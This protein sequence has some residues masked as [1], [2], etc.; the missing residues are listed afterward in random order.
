MKQYAKRMPHLPNPLGTE[1]E[2][3]K[4]SELDMLQRLDLLF[5]LCEWQ[6]TG[7][8]RLRSMMNEEDEL[9]W[10]S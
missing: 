3:I 5:N 9:F 8:A 2:P 1:E 10:V 4:W 6:F 7:T